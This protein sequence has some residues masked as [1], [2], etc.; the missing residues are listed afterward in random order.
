MMG[1]PG[2]MYLN[3]V[4]G[5]LVLAAGLWL[6]VLIYGRSIRRRKLRLGEPYNR[7]AVISWFILILASVLA[8]WYALERAISYGHYYGYW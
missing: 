7:V 5:P 4:G 3:S 1:P 6:F 2:C 8:T